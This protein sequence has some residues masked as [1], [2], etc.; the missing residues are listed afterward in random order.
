MF[1]SLRLKLFFLICYEKK[2]FFEKIKGLLCSLKKHLKTLP[3]KNLGN[4]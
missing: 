4:F 1:S 3:L 2:Y